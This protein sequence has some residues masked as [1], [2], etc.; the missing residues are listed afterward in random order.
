MRS[1]WSL[2]NL[3]CEGM[4]HLASESF[5][6]DLTPWERLALRSHLF[7]CRACCR[8]VRQ[9]KLLANRPARLA[10]GIETDDLLPGPDLPQSAKENIKKS[11][12]AIKSNDNQ[13]PPLLSGFRIA[14]DT[15]LPVPS[16]RHSI[17]SSGKDTRRGQ[18]PCRLARLTRDR[19]FDSFPIPGGT[20]VYLNRS[21][22]SPQRS[23][24]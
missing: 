17:E 3:P 7:Y 4:A 5:D 18:R 6:H 20:A 23:Q 19:A 1:L 11:L 14:V 15:S 8:Y 22:S 24:L 13:F 16:F 12:K 10:S 2:L 21:G 9:L